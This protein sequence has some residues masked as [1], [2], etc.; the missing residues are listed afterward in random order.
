MFISHKEKKN[1]DSVY[2]I[3]NT[4]CDEK[5]HTNKYAIAWLLCE[6]TIYNSD[7]IYDYLKESNINYD[8]KRIA[9]SKMYDSFRID[10]AAY[11]KFKE[12]KEE[13][14]KLNSGN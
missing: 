1:R 9:I 7:I 3:L 4:I 14:M 12:L 13:L 8:I 10:R 2:K 5:E 6:L 11:N